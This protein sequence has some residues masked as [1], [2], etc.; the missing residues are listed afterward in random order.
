MRLAVISDIHANDVALRT[1]LYDAAQCGVDVYA[2]LGDVVGYGPSPAECVRLARDSFSV[3][4]LG[5]HDAAVCGLRGI[6][7]FSDY[8]AEAV[9]VQRK[10]LGPVEKTYLKLL[11]L[12][13]HEGDVAM[14]HGDFTAPGEFRYVDDERTAAA[15]F[16]ARSERVMFIGH[17]HEP[18]VWILDET[19]SVTRL[20]AADIKLLPNR[21]YI[22]NPG[23]VGYPRGGTDV[24]G[25]YAIYDDKANAVYFRKVPF[26]MNAYSR[27]LR[28]VGR[29]VERSKAAGRI[30][31]VIMAAVGTILGVVALGL[32]A[33]L[34]QRMAYDKGKDNTAER[35]FVE[36]VTTN[37]VIQVIDK[38]TITNYIVEV[39]A[40]GVKKSSRI[41]DKPPVDIEESIPPVT[42][43]RPKPT[44]VVAKTPQS[45]VPASV[46]MPV[47][48]ENKP[49]TVITPAQSL[50]L[51]GAY[52][53]DEVR[54][55]KNTNGT[56]DVIH[57]FTEDVKTQTLVVPERN[58]IV[59]SSAS[60]LVVGGGG[61]TGVGYTGGGGA[62]GVVFRELQS[63]VSGTV[64]IHVGAGGLAHKH[65]GKGFVGDRNG[66]DSFLT[67]GGMTYTALGGGAGG[68]CSG[69]SGG[70]AKALVGWMAQALQPKSPSGGMGVGVGIG[71][72]TCS[73]CGGGSEYKSAIS[74]QWMTYAYGGRCSEHA[75]KS[76]NAP[77]IGDGAD[78]K[79]KGGPFAGRNGVVIVR[80]SVKTS[81]GNLAV[82]PISPT[83]PKP[84]A[85]VKTAMIGGI[86]WR[87]FVEK[88]NT[89]TIG[90]HGDGSVD[91]PDLW[92]PAVNADALSG[93]VRIPDGI[94]GKPVRKIGKGAFQRCRNVTRFVV[95]EGVTHCGARAFAECEQ[96]QSV[97]YP[98]SLIWLGEGQVFRSPKIDVIGF[99]SCPPK[100]ECGR[101]P[102]KGANLFM[103]IVVPFSVNAKWR[104]WGD[105]K[106]YHYCSD[107]CHRQLCLTSPSAEEREQARKTH[108]GFLSL[109]VPW[110]FG[111]WKKGQA[112][113]RDTRNSAMEYIAEH[114]ETMWEDYLSQSK[115]LELS[116]L[117]LYTPVKGIAEH[118]AVIYESMMYF[119]AGEPVS[120]KY[121][122]DDYAMISV[123]GQ[124]I[125][126]L[127]TYDKWA[128]AKWFSCKDP[129]S[130]SKDGWHRISL[131]AANGMGDG[132]ASPGFT[133]SSPFTQEGG[134]FYKRG[135][136]GEWRRFEATPN[137]KEFRVTYFDVRRAIADIER[138]KQKKQQPPDKKRKN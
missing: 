118:T 60:F 70:G 13:W 117:C 40:N 95:P 89:I 58:L 127:S 74:G 116:P 86:A 5:N 85:V 38:V 1:A 93:V 19:G 29:N 101:C 78:W 102:F 87:Y 124:V 33:L 4:L 56:I 51:G 11:P 30:R 12:V 2:S 121:C 134:V 138:A 68:G 39:W 27:A 133:Y 97:V 100:T 54:A 41:L 37:R 130:F 53:G 61:A 92:T 17:T 125:V 9:R 55:I 6:S 123:D 48:D 50:A 34:F 49:Y 132:G 108:A 15:N 44:P 107:G 83:F 128:W 112:L 109:K 3:S 104:N 110:K 136:K 10:Q 26:D 45:V 119:K 75:Q 80:Y 72:W 59:P 96:L 120:F 35:K 43:T 98:K 18:G 67:I 81:E 84:D 77:N 47:I 79:S 24:C 82:Q 14:T 137:G 73:R 65:N 32:L 7:D 129:V 105:Y 23:T 64:Y 20:P 103:R 106:S 69:G 90:C 91:F 16:A 76:P 22:I 114:V 52:G 36:V 21:R 88:D 71:E 31:R 63:I 28:A 46:P 135:D 8:A 94:D 62:G 66:E 25:T 115:A 42:Q 131:V 111:P 113:T 126:P 122:I 57:V 99:Q